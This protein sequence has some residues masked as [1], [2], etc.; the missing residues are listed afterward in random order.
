MFASKSLCSLCYSR[1]AVLI[2]AFLYSRHTTPQKQ[3]NLFR[4]P[5]TLP[6]SSLFAF[7]GCT[8]ASTL[9]VLYPIDFHVAKMKWLWAECYFLCHFVQSKHYFHCHLWTPYLQ[10]LLH[11]PDV[12]GATS[13]LTAKR[14]LF[15]KQKKYTECRKKYYMK[16]WQKFSHTNKTFS[17][18]SIRVPFHS[19]THRRYLPRKKQSPRSGCFRI[20]FQ[21]SNALHSN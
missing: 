19:F 14:S 15:Q 8:I 12:R 4:D 20:P 5:P 9:Y 21:S 17:F 6:F 7:Q 2:F 1:A 11:A 10:H 3:R 18:G 13:S 16:S